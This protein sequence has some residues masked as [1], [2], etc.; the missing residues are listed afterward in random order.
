VPGH[1]EIPAWVIEGYAT[2]LWEIED[3]LARTSAAGPDLVLVQIGVGALAGAVI[4]HYRQRGLARD[5]RPVRIVGVEPESAACALEALAVDH[6]VS[7]DG[8]HTSIMAGLNCGTLASI[9]WPAVRAGLDAAVALDDERAEEAMRAFDEHGVVSGESG[10]AGL[11]G[12]LELLKGPDSARART[13]LGL[14]SRT[15]VLVIST[16]GITDPLAYR[17]IVG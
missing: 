10:A 4:A 9:V 12:L 7:L 8:P 1:E 13:A 2:I 16:E 11:A 14:D 3:E 17:R 5:K 6:V 15:R